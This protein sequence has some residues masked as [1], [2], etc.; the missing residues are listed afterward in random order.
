MHLEGKHA[1]FGSWSS[2]YE[3]CNPGLVVWFPS[4]KWLLIISVVSK[5][6]WEDLLKYKLSILLQIEC[7]SNG[8]YTAV[9]GEGAASNST[10]LWKNLCPLCKLRLSIWGGLGKKKLTHSLDD[11]LLYPLFSSLFFLFF[12]H[13]CTLLFFFYNLHTPTKFFRQYKN[14]SVFTFY[15]LR[16]CL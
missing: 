5:F 14:Y 12:F 6:Y 2:M 8:G 16:E 10:G 1:C 13:L 7:S 9:G 11:F 3:L 4:D 15:F